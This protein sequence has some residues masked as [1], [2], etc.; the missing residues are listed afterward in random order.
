L[1]IPEI[2]TYRYVVSGVW[3][4]F[5]SPGGLTLMTVTPQPTDHPP[6]HV[7]DPRTLESQPG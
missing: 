3:H 6:V 2:K 1:S 7:D 4:R 5:S